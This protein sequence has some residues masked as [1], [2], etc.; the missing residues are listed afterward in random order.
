MASIFLK[1]VAW[2]C[3]SIGLL[4]GFLSLGLVTPVGDAL[5]SAAVWVVLG[6]VVWYFALRSGLRLQRE[7]QSQSHQK[8]PTT[9]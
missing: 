8:P 6:F 1:T 9:N 7:S 3:L 5:F 4:F 2:I